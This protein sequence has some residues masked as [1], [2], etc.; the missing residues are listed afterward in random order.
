[1]QNIGKDICCNC[2]ETNKECVELE[3]LWMF[4]YT[5]CQ[6]CVSKAFRSFIKGK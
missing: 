4:K 5:L 1:M 6:R 2:G 3:L